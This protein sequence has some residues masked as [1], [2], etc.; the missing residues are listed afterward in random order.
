MK[1]LAGPVPGHDRLPQSLMIRG[2]LSPRD[3]SRVDRGSLIEARQPPARSPEAG[4]GLVFAHVDAEPDPPT[5]SLL[6]G[7]LWTGYM[8]AA[9]PC[10]CW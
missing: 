7:G 3:W 10:C 2:V 4:G 9:P 5:D 1:G 8:A 6:F